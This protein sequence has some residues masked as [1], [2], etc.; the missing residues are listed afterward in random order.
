MELVIITFAVERDR[1]LTGV[2]DFSLLG[3]EYYQNVFA[4][5][6]ILILS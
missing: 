5:R 1:S 6:R 2:T 4:Y 3:A